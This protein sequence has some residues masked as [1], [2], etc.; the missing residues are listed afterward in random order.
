MRAGDPLEPMNRVIF[1]FNGVVDKAILVPA[2]KTYRGVTPKPARD[3]IHN[4]LNNLRSPVI[5]INDVLQ[6][7]WSRAGD[8]LTRFAINST[9]GVGGLVDV[10]KRQGIKRHKEDFGQTMAVAGITPGPY[11]VLPLLGPS[12]FRDA[13]GRI[14][15]QFF[16]P[17]HYVNYNGQNTVTDVR[18]VV[19]VLDKRE[20]SLKAVKKL[21]RNSLDRYASYRDLY[22]QKRKQKISNKE[23]DVQ[24]LPEFDISKK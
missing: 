13:I 11:L 3:G 12:N 10:A 5:L 18:R 23:L 19:N 9:V 16:S 2:A 6:G 21:R 4:F 15:D 24:A 7:E 1:T 14:P 20:R 17:L 8:T 22:R